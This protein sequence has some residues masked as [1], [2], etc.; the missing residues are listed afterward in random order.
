MKEKASF[1]KILLTI[2][3]CLAV[4]VLAGCA[5]SPGYPLAPAEEP[6]LEEEYRYQ[7][8][9]GD[10]VQIFMWGNQEL[11]GSFPVRPDGMITTYLV[12][13]IPASGMTP[14]ELARDLEAVY[15]NYVRSPVVTVI[16]NGFVGIP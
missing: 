13:D 14:T 5:T 11:S 10:S 7:I 9:P 3:G 1:H 16:V 6:L 15:S 8:G 2:A 12:E 4:I